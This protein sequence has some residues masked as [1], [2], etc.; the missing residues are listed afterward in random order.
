M[1]RIATRF[2]AAR[3]HKIQRYGDEPGRGIKRPFS[4]IPEWRAPAIAA[5]THRY[6]KR[7]ASFSLRTIGCPVEQPNAFANSGMFVIGP[8][9]RQ[10]S[11]ECEFI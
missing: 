4:A 5:S 8:I 9:I 2:S 7:T 10:L 1:S 6:Q 11:G 3:E